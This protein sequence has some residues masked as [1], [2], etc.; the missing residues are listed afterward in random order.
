MTLGNAARMAVVS[1]G[2]LVT[3]QVPVCNICRRIFLQTVRSPGLLVTLQ[4][5]VCNRIYLVRSLHVGVT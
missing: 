4:V 3:L 1:P 2:L 5:P